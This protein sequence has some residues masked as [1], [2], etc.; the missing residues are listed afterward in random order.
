MNKPIYYSDVS[1]SQEYLNEKKK[2]T[3]AYSTLPLADR[4]RIDKSTNA[5]L[6]SDENTERMRSWNEQKRD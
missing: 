3:G 4:S 1:H 2:I 6:P 5:A